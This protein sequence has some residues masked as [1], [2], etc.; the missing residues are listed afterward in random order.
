MSTLLSSQYSFFPDVIYS[1]AHCS[2]RR[3]IRWYNRSS[4]GAR[5]QRAHQQQLQRTTVDGELP[6]RDL[7]GRRTTEEEIGGGRGQPLAVDTEGEL[8]YAGSS[9]ASSTRS[10]PQEPL[11]PPRAHSG[12]TPSTNATGSP[13]P[14]DARSTSS[15]PS[16]RP[17]SDSSP[18]TAESASSGRSLSSPIFVKCIRHHHTHHAHHTHAAQHRLTLLPT[19]PPQPLSTSEAVLFTHYTMQ[20]LRAERL[21]CSRIASLAP[22]ELVG[23]G[24]S[25]GE[26]PPEGPLAL[27]WTDHGGQPLPELWRL[28]SLGRRLVQPEEGDTADGDEARDPSPASPSFFNSPPARGRPVPCS[29]AD[30]LHFAI[31]LT[32]RLHELHSAD[33]VYNFLHPTVILYKESAEHNA[34]QL[35]DYTFATLSPAPSASAPSPSPLLPPSLL[36]TLP[37][38][39]LPLSFL[40]YVAPEMFDSAASLSPSLS[41]DARSDL[42]SLGISLYELCTGRPPFFSSTANLWR[43]RHWHRAKLPRPLSFPARWSGESPAAGACLHLLGDVVLKLLS[44]GVEHRYQ[45]AAGLLFDLRHLQ[46]M[47]DPS[48]P[49]QPSPSASFAVGSRDR[50]ATFRVSPSFYDRDELVQRLLQLYEGVEASAASKERLSC[51]AQLRGERG[52]GKSSLLQ[53]FQRRLHQRWGDEHT[54]CVVYSRFDDASASSMGEHLPSVVFLLQSMQSLVIQSLTAIVDVERGRSLL[55]Q[56]VEGYERLCQLLLPGLKPFMDHLTVSPSPSGSTT[57]PSPSPASP[58]SDGWD[59]AVATSGFAD[60][61]SLTRRLLRAFAG[62]SNCV[63]LLVDDAH[64]CDQQGRDFIDRLLDP[65]A[66]SLTDLPHLLLIATF[67]ASS[68]SSHPP[69]SFPASLHLTLPPLQLPS[70]TQ[71]VRDS[72]MQDCSATPSLT[73]TKVSASPSARAV[74]ASSPSTVEELAALLLLKTGGYPDALHRALHSLHSHQLLHFDYAS[75]LWSWRLDAVKFFDLGPPNPALLHSRV[76]ALTN[77]QSRALRVASCIGQEFTLA[78]IALCLSI[79]CSAVRELLLPAVTAGLVL[80]TGPGLELPTVGSGLSEVSL[81]FLHPSVRNSFY[82]L[83]SSAFRQHVHLTYARSFLQPV[84]GMSDE[85]SIQRRVEE[86]I[87]DIVHHYEL[88][89]ALITPRPPPEAAVKAEGQSASSW[90]WE[91]ELMKVEEL[92]QVVAF[93]LAASRAA[94]RLKDSALALQHAQFAY[95]CTQRL[96]DFSHH[97]LPPLGGGGGKVAAVASPWVS[98]Y[99]VC[100]ALFRQYASLLY[101]GGDIVQADAVVSTALLHTTTTMDH[102]RLH[103]L[104]LDA[105]LVRGDCSAAVN[106]GLQVLELLGMRLHPYNAEEMTAHLTEEAVTALLSQAEQQRTGHTDASVQVSHYLARLLMPSWL[107]GRYFLDVL[108]TC[109]W[110]MHSHGLTLYDPLAIAFYS[111]PLLSADPPNVELA[112][113]LCSHTLA[114]LRDTVDLYTQNRPVAQLI[115]L[116]LSVTYA[117]FIAPWKAPLHDTIEQLEELRRGLQLLSSDATVVRSR[118]T[119]SHLDYHYCE[120]LFWTGVPLRRVLVALQEAASPKRGR[121]VLLYKEHYRAT[122]LVLTTLMRGEEHKQSAPRAADTEPG[123]SLAAGD[124]G[125]VS[126]FL[127]RP[128]SD[129]TEVAPIQR[130]SAASNSVTFD[131]PEPS[132]RLPLTPAASS[133]SIVDVSFELEQRLSALASSSVHPV[134]ASVGQVWLLLWHFLTSNHKAALQLWPRM[135]TQERT[136]TA[137]ISHPH[138]LFLSALCTAT[139]ATER[140]QHRS[141]AESASPRQLPRSTTAPASALFPRPPVAELVQSVQEL[142]AEATDRYATAVNFQHKWTLVEAELLKLR[143]LLGDVPRLHAYLPAL[144]LYDRA[145]AAARQSLSL[146]DEAIACELA[147]R[148]TLR[149]QRHVEANEL[150]AAGSGR[151]PRLGMPPQGRRP[152]ARVR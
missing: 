79:P 131:L 98:D 146:L 102:V 50:A 68:P 52:I 127:I 13:W 87:L 139:E 110:L 42:Y 12:Q 14:S 126:P 67:H 49:P 37:R 62:P 47:L 21:L 28:G 5:Q 132:P 22:V 105:A 11:L 39:P 45:T 141:G 136:A 71:L 115:Q 40:P 78:A 15:T 97:R 122:R 61:T 117:V 119:V 69:L 60:V 46:S 29:L 130:M 59:D 43:M 75:G 89:T 150:P 77:E 31:G 121:A 84:D 140:I 65:H 55:A 88:C 73:L 56:A 36:S 107:D 133:S 81:R 58:S 120:R 142:L 149:Y 134:L 72:L 129:V 7:D 128:M 94:Q 10:F 64:L 18:G 147:G 26:Q 23:E 143:M 3:G 109:A 96:V 54:S 17:S 135:R 92:R 19:P 38:P 125:D 25:S 101:N 100:L 53:L 20:H 118:I 90:D 148:F 35:L 104:R 4:S 76:H 113:A 114:H 70:I 108:A 111:I 103:D 123:D 27:A 51:V 116:Q 57:L 74:V 2:I 151:I 83:C 63:V 99:E 24:G 85:Q 93:A 124:G 16:D 82:D 138:T 145:I 9:A 6:D 95:S 32:E 1:D 48:S 144:E 91:A 41:S 86:D 66:H 44:K 33:V 137:L 34:V 8:S 112:H 30:F 80:P 152:L 106:T